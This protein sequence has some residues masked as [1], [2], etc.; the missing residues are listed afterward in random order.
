ME[1]PLKCP[2]C[3]S[4]NSKFCYYNNYSHATSVRLA[5]GTGPKEA[6]YAMFPSAAVVARPRGLNQLPGF[7]PT[8]PFRDFLLP[9]SFHLGLKWLFRVSVDYNP[10]SSSTIEDL[11]FE[12]VLLQSID[13]LFH[14]RPSLTRSLSSRALRSSTHRMSASDRQQDPLSFSGR[15]AESP[16]TSLSH[17]LLSP[18][19]NPR[20]ANLLAG[21]F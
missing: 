10:S 6:L 3:D 1:Q 5:G 4:P 19:R 2:R 21:R 18:I 14:V 16:S 8:F 13:M 15:G 7:L 17:L 11:S 9:S 20:P 12:I